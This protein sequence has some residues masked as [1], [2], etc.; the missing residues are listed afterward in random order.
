MRERGPLLT[1][2]AVLFA[3]LGISNLLKPFQVLGGE[4]GFV[5]FG[6]RLTGTANAI[7]GPAFGVL[8]LVYAA[9]LWGMRRWALPLAWA[10]AAYVVANLILFMVRTPQEPGA[11]RMLF[12][13]VYAAVALGVSIGTALLLRRR[14][15]ELV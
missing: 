3:I 6:E 8:L 4:T 1:T 14:R 7:A 15:D 10:Y 11:G 12:G 2:A 9:G 13:L 5:L